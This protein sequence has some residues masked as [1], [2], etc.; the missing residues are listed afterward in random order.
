MRNTHASMRE[1]PRINL[2]YSRSPK[3]MK[4]SRETN[5][6]YI[7]RRDVTMALLIPA[8]LALMNPAMIVI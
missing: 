1:M 8:F 4:E 2:A 7:D 5:T 3:I 6:T